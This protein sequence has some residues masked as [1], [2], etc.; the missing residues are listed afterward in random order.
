MV[1]H[2]SSAH[3]S[4]EMQRLQKILADI[5]GLEFLDVEH[6]ED[7]WVA[8]VYSTSNEANWVA[9]TPLDTPSADLENWL[10]DVLR[11]ENIAGEII[12][13]FSD[14]PKRRNFF[15]WVRVRVPQDP[16][17][18]WPLWSLGQ[19]LRIMSPKRDYALEISPEIEHGQYFAADVR[20]RGQKTYPDKHDLFAGDVVAVRI[21]DEHFALSA[22]QDGA[23]VVWRLGDRGVVNT[24]EGYRWLV[25]KA[26]RIDKSH[27]LSLSMLWNFHTGAI[28][29]RIVNVSDLLQVSSTYIVFTRELRFANQAELSR[30]YALVL[31]DV[32]Q[33][34]IV[35]IAEMG[36]TFVLPEARL[37]DD[38][39][40]LSYLSGSLSVFNVKTGKVL[41]TLVGHTDIIAATAM[42]DGSHLLSASDDH[43]MRLWNLYRG[44]CVQTIEGLQTPVRSIAVLDRT[45]VLTAGL[46]N[47]LY[48]WNVRR[49]DIVGTYSLG[50][51]TDYPLPVSSLQVLP[52]RDYVVINFD[53]DLPSTTVQIIPLTQSNDGQ[54]WQF[55]E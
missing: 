52:A 1:H 48:I 26:I 22:L 43:T 12:L 3:A 45:H 21:L 50:H 55:G 44:T 40:V 47:T 27:I 8:W 39:V 18:A 4:P 34:Q 20:R 17:W 42:L 16:A 10:S 51:G 31:W 2:A 53:S 6:F 41:H 9:Q 33:W 35:R 25:E 49:G 28:E 5:P 7:P 54:Q 19:D 24:L 38:Y 29:R 36:D 30:E 23:L 37:D 13:Y 14:E 15:P 32:K 46:D 11:A